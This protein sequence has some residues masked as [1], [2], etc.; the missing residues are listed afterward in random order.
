MNAPTGLQYV[1]FGIQQWNHFTLSYLV[2]CWVWKEVILRPIP[3]VGLCRKYLLCFVVDWL[4]PKCLGY[5]AASGIFGGEFRLQQCTI[6]VTR[7]RFL[8]PHFRLPAVLLQ[9]L[10]SIKI[11]STD[12]VYTEV[13][14][15]CARSLI[16]SSDHFVSGNYK[17][18][19]LIVYHWRNSLS[20]IFFPFYA[21]SIYVAFCRNP[22][23]ACNDSHLWVV[24][25]AIWLQSHFHDHPCIVIALK[26]FEIW[27]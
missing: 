15:R 25:H 27:G 17:L 18:R 21:F 9:F 14:L 16:D 24:H 1:L 20:F 19:F 6:Q 12:T 10:K 4:F 22:T 3:N 5:T 2:L 26:W 23:P 11:L 8:Y 13:H 7:T